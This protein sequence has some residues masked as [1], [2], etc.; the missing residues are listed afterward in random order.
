M[1]IQYA[2]QLAVAA[3]VM[4]VDAE[5]SPTSAKTI[6]QMD[7]PPSAHTPAN[8]ESETFVQGLSHTVGQDEDRGQNEDL[9]RLISLRW[10]QMLAIWTARTPVGMLTHIKKLAN[11]VKDFNS[12]F[13]FYKILYED[14]AANKVL[15]V[16]AEQI[17]N[18][19][20]LALKLHEGAKL[21]PIA[22]VSSALESAQFFE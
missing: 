1:R 8:D 5:T 22:E 15:K 20:K 13:K 6:R 9:V 14:S 21:E 16:L 12:V 19:A 18:P 17:G 2:V 7:I 3:M 10:A 11:T 4:Y